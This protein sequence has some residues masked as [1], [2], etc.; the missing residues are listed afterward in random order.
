MSGAEVFDT[1]TGELSDDGV[2]PFHPLANLFPLMADEEFAGLVR[3]VKENGV[4]EPIV[5]HEDAIL[6]G[7]NR[8]RAA[9]E[10]SVDCP[11][12]PFSGNDAAA[13]VVSLNVHRRH[14]SE[15]QRAMIAARLANVGHGGGRNF[16][17]SIE[18]LKAIEGVSEDRAAKLMSV[19]H[20]SV[21]RAKVVQR[22][23][24]PELSDLVDRA[25]ISV[26]AAANV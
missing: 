4:R 20:A 12:V 8:Y 11:T 24:I 16:K 14:L 18:A 19:S 23:A 25:E 7:R 3:D 1:E 9:R 6:D 10:S 2:L 22:K 13:F 26:S 21:E 5:L 17:T 15:S